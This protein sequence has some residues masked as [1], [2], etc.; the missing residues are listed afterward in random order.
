M[1]LTDRP[2]HAFY[3]LFTAALR[4]SAPMKQYAWVVGA[5]LA[6]TAAGLAM[7]GRFELVNI[8]MV[9]VLAVVV[10]AV[11]FSRGPAAA[12]ALLSVLAFDIVFVPP[13]GTFSV[14][15]AQYLFTFAI[16]LVVGLLVSRLTENIRLQAGA[17][18][19]LEVQA[20]T[21]RVR[22]TLL[23]SISHDLRTPLAV[24]SGAS[25]ALA[26]RGERMSAEERRA[27]ARSVFEQ[28][29]DMSE[30]VAKVLQMTR[31]EAGAIELERGWDSIAEIAEAVLRRLRERLSGHRVVVE[32]ADDVP[33]V[34]VDA[35]LVEQALGNLLENAARHTPPE[36]LI[37]LRARRHGAELVVSVED[38]GPGLP[39]ADLERIFAKFD[40]RAAEGPAGGVGLGLSNCRAIVELHGGRVWAEPVPGG[41]TAF[42]FTLPIEEAPG[43][44]QEAA[45]AGPP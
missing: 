44:P 38:F 2:A 36:T 22:S 8:A 17:R 24:M 23:A 42:R 31:L 3:G 20:A 15:D 6:C 13:R 18:A 34:R 9:Y 30:Q 14:D 29:R 32:L 21:E 7:R 45:L 19:R 39:Q 26:E 25:S 16:M 28:A 5:T 40:R 4:Y 12:T 35:T 27:L 37:R 43:L 41:G 1:P 11:R 33:L 10:V